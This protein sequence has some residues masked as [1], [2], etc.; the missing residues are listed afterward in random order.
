[1]ADS[2][3]A[4]L[5]GHHNSPYNPCRILAQSSRML[6]WTPATRN[7]LG[8]LSDVVCE[9]TDWTGQS[10]EIPGGPL[11]L[12]RDFLAVAVQTPS[13]LPVTWGTISADP[14]NQT[15]IRV[16]WNTFTEI[17]NDYFIVGRSLDGVAFQ[18]IGTVSGNGTTTIPHEYFFDDHDVM[19][20]V[21]YYYQIHQVDYDGHVLSSKIVSAQLKPH[22]EMFLMPNITETSA[23]LISDQEILLSVTLT[24]S[25]GYMIRHQNV[26]SNSVMIDMSQQP[27]GIYFVT[28]ITKSGSRTCKLIKQ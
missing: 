10:T 9:F 1:M 25:E 22:I 17:N 5:V 27:T 23:K 8:N 7:I 19:T 24:N 6:D 16:V 26:E 2:V 14:F 4:T 13:L 18:T 12:S 20:G 15:T 28:G 21:P 3:Q 11:V